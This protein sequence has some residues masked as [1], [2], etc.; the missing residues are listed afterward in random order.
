MNSRRLHL[1]AAAVLLSGSLLLP[2]C[3]P[4][5]AAVAAPLDVRVVSARPFDHAQSDTG[6][7]AFLG[8]LRGD[9]ETSLSFKVNGQIARIGP[10]DGTEDWNEG[11]AVE[12]DAVL[13]QLDTA[14]FVNAVAAARARTEYARAAFARTAELFVAANLSKNEFEASRAQKD[15]AEA[16]LAQAEQNL[17]D[18]TLRAPYTGTVLARLAKSNEY[19]AAGRPVLRVGGFRQMKLEIGV[20]DTLLGRLGV[21]QDYPVKVSAFEGGEFTGRLSELGTAAAEGSRL[22]RVVLEISNGDGRL[23]SGMTATV[24]LGQYG[25]PL[26]AGV[27]VPLS[28]LVSPGRAGAAPG[29]IAVFVVGD[30]QMARERLVRTGDLIQSSI[31]VTDG[32]RAGERIVS[33]G[34]GQL[35]DGARVNATPAAP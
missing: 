23:K 1:F 31:V 35:F 13:A 16:D 24:R 15:T 2:A 4:R 19:A 28:A 30:D 12:K 27:L 14:N 26:S 25:A 8:L 22:F 3:K 10:A 32:L 7:A 5:I 9:P 17:R 11:A 20:P 33:V 6:G 34:A 18:T 21:G 29:T